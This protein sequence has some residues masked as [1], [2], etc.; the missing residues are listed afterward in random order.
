[1]DSGRIMLYNFKFSSAYEAPRGQ[2][3][4]GTGFAIGLV[5]GP[6][7]GG[8]FAENPNATWRWVSLLG[9][10]WIAKEADSC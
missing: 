1:M 8:A 2:A 5:L 4:I 10:A 9:P 7:V 3:V 6:I